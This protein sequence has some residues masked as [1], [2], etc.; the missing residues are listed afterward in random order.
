MKIDHHERDTD[1]WH[2]RRTW[3][4][5]AEDFDTAPE[6]VRLAHRFEDVITMGWDMAAPAKGGR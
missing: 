3:D 2:F 4:S 6:V 5:E 1:G